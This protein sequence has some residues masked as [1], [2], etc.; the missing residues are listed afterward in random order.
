[1]DWKDLLGVNLRDLEIEPV[2]MKLD[3]AITRDDVGKPVKISADSTAALCADGDI[4]YGVLYHVDV[5]PDVGAIRPLCFV[6]V[7]YTGAPVLGYQPLNANGLGGLKPPAVGQEGRPLFVLAIDE[8]AG[9]MIVDC[10]C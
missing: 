10:G 9:T 6:E 1:M 7:P 8:A 2:T 3:L 4:P 5:A